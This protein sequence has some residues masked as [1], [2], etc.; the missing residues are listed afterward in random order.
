MGIEVGLRPP[1]PSF[2]HHPKTI[3]DIIDQTIGK[4]FDFIEIEHELF[5]RWGENADT[6]QRIHPLTSVLVNSNLK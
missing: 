6:G 4:I 2:Y 3:C 1:V 5:Q